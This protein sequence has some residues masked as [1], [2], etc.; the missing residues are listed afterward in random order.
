MLRKRFVYV[1]VDEEHEETG[2]KEATRG[3]IDCVAGRVEESALRHQC[4]RLFE[5]VPLGRFSLPS[6]IRSE[7]DERAE[8]PDASDHHQCR[9][10]VPFV[11]VGDRRRDRP[12]SVQTNY[13]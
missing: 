1:D 6:Q 4:V 2:H 10:F 7:T 8:Q 5:V 13:R 3:R 9:V 11:D 12:V